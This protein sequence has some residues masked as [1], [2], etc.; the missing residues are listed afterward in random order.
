[1]DD[2]PDEVRVL[3][4]DDEPSIVDVISMVLRCQG[5]AVEGAITGQEVLE[6]AR[7]RRAAMTI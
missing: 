3:V 5:F 4:V 2:R 6:H 7:R 1:V